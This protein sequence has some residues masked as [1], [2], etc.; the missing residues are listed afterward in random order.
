[1]FLCIHTQ[2]MKEENLTTADKA[3]VEP[4]IS[5]LHGQQ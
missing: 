2:I 4:P 3:S 1:M 5:Y